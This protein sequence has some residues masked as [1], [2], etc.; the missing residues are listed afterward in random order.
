M[1]GRG[2]TKTQNQGDTGTR[3]ILPPPRLKFK[4]TQTVG[5]DVAPKEASMIVYQ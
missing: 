5:S 4:D 3:D 2:F 1:S